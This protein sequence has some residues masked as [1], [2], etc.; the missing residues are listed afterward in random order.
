MPRRASPVS[1]GALRRGRSAFAPTTDAVAVEE[2]LELRLGDAVLTT[3]MRTPGADVELA[4][5]WLLAEGIV[6]GA[7]EVASAVFDL[8][9]GGDDSHNVLR[10][11]LAPGVAPP[12]AARVRIATTTSSWG[13]CGSSAIDAIAV[14]SAWPA[15]DD[16][17]VLGVD[18]LTALPDRLRQR[19]P[20][21]GETGGTHGAALADTEGTILAVRE[22]V[23]RHNAVD[24]VLGWASMAGMVPLRGRVLVLSGRAGFELVQKAA[25]AGVPFVV[26]V[27]APTALA[28]D[29]AERSGI[30]LVGFV[31]DG[32][33]NVYTRPDRIAL[34]G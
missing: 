18:V 21:F 13:V 8:G 14:G 6:S 27:G 7:E 26:A 30:T 20:L 11:E 9:V 16:G 17:A 28:V 15:D 23:G 31:R 19:Q 2:P 12:D 24:K 3:T 32:G 34:G 33:A 10:V 29:V 25:M 22:D 1:V 4:H 5:G